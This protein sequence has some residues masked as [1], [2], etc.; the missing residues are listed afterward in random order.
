MFFCRGCLPREGLV[1]KE[2]F[3]R[4]LACPLDELRALPVGRLRALL[5]Q[6]SWL[7]KVGSK[8]GSTPPA[9]AKA[10][11]VNQLGVMSWGIDGESGDE[12]SENDRRLVQSHMR[13]SSTV[14]SE[15]ECE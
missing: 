13:Q 9:L 5:R 14:E 3:A 11:S 7:S 2:D 8:D 1:E 15:N 10:G 12:G 6:S 4:A